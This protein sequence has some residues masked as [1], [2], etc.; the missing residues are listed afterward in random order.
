MTIKMFFIIFIF[1]IIVMYR[2]AQIN[3]ALKDY[4]S[5]EFD[6]LSALK[7]IPKDD[8]ATTDTTTTATTATASIDILLKRVRLNLKLQRKQ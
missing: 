7:R 2:R 6:L 1:F 4:E 3:E 5:A 8:C